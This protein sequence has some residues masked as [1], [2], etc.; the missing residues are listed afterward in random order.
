M[1]DDFN[2]RDELYRRFRLALKRPVGE[3][4]FDEDEL[5]EI[6][7]YAGD[8]NDDYVQSE[9]LFCGARLYPESQALAERRALYYLDTTIDDS[10]RPSP[11]TASFL[12]DNPD[13][14][15]PIFDIIR[16]DLNRPD[17][18]EGALEY[19]LTQ[20]EQFSDEEMIRFVQLAM[21]LDCYD[22]MKTNFD[23]L[24]KMN[25]NEAV[26][27][28]EAI[29]YA[30]E[31]MDDVFVEKLAEELIEVD[32]FVVLYWQMLFRAQARQQKEEEARATFDS[33]R[34]LAADEP[35]MQLSLAG[36]VYN[37]AP[38]L[39]DEAI[40]MVRTLAQESPSEFA[41]TDCLCALLVRSGRTGEAV[42][43]L[44]KFID[45]N[46][47]NEVAMR[48]LMTCDLSDTDKYLKRF[49]EATGGEGFPDN[50]YYDLINKLT[51]NSIHNSLIALVEQF[52]NFEDMDANEMAAYIEALFA[53][54][55]YE[56]VTA[57]ID[58]YKYADAMFML[59]LKGTA[60]SFAYMVSLV[61]TGRHD[62]A[63]AHYDKQ[64]ELLENMLNEGP[65]PIRM[66]VRCL[67]NLVDR[68]HQ[69]P[70][71]D[72]MFWDYFDVLNYGKF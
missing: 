1:S 4:F 55:R 5:V 40:D 18:A 31:R 13:T 38:Y 41:F 33:A 48:Q 47:A 61:K 57:V 46:P 43:V 14:T 44:K 2:P 23:R 37:I 54:G 11:A 24:R 64:R 10:D 30:D 45:S 8:L 22:W 65:M 53:K 3:R 28:Y 21:D 72:K 60:A 69:H 27:L 29:H 34:S 7:D 63:L 36:D 49:S 42:S 52:G 19:L 62:D 17:D 59:P 58:G 25:D 35:M 67:L 12:E 70:A 68:I 20:Y 50:V 32:A 26:L 71:E 51:L 66:A 15:S 9:V 6:Y 39:F 16:L 56:K